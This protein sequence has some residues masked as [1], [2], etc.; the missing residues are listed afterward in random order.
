[1]E[2]ELDSKTGSN[3]VGMRLVGMPPMN[4]G[5]EIDDIDSG[6][7]LGAYAAA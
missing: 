2:C 3:E 4:A 6:G 1:L 7:S 5:S